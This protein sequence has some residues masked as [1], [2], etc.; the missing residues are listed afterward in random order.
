MDV[1]GLRRDGGGSTRAVSRARTRS[2]GHV[3]AGR[4][5]PPIAQASGR[6]QGNPELAPSGWPVHQAQPLPWLFPNFRACGAPPPLRLPTPPPLSLPPSTFSSASDILQLPRPQP[7]LSL[8]LP[9]SSL[10]PPSLLSPLP[11]PRELLSTPA[12]SASVFRFHSP[13]TLRWPSRGAL[14]PLLL[15]RYRRPTGEIRTS[16]SGPQARVEEFAGVEEER[17]RG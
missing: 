8:S 9:S 10:S 7:S 5:A 15:M 11:S 1:E 3:L 2:P 14:S 4:K 17:A 16:S 12:R 13:L 6:A